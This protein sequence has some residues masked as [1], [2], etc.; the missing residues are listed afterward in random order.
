MNYLFLDRVNQELIDN[1]HKGNFEDWKPSDGELLLEF[2]E[3]LGK[4][5]KALKD[6]NIDFVRKYSASLA[7]YSEKTFNLYTDIDKLCYNCKFFVGHCSLL[8]I[9]TNRFDP[10][11]D[12]KEIKQNEDLENGKS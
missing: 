2:Y 12:G 8:G 9:P 5:Q 11:C 10:F 6:K 3:H 7:L 1:Q 4:L